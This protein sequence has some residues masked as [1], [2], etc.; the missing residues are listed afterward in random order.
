MPAASKKSHSVGRSES[1]NVVQRLR[2]AVR[3]A[4]QMGFEVRKVVLDEQSAGWCQI[5]SKKIL[6]LDLAATAGEQ[7][8]QVEEIIGA[9]QR[10]R[11][12]S[13]VA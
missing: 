1:L 11:S 3:N 5:G 13:R 12:T 6:F 2:V 10:Y 7:L 9:F 4:E 8:R